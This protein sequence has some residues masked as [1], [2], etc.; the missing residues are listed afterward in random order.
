MKITIMTSK[1]SYLNNYIKD[2]EESFEDYDFNFITNKED[3]KNGDIAFYLSCYELIKNE[4]LAKNKHN[5]V[6]HESD[7]PQGKGWSPASWQILKGNNELTLSL[8]EVTSKVDSGDIYFKDKLIL[9][10]TELKDQ[11]QAKIV[12]KKIEMCLKFI[13]ELSNLKP[14]KQIGEETFYPRRTPEDCELD[15]NKTIKEQFNLLRIVDND[16]YPAFFTYK[17]RKYKI[18][19]SEY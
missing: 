4:Y 18:T 1:N 13:N 6:I 9:D 8:F 16:L 11:W 19:I 10:G 3:I 12:K 15:I 7:L 5:I 2:I 17:G 14:Q